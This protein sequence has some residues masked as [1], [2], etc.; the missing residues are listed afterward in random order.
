MYFKPN[1]ESA[2][3]VVEDGTAWISHWNMAAI[4]C[5]KMECLHRH[6][7][8]RAEKGYLCDDFIHDTTPFLGITARDCRF[9]CVA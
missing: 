9:P 2:A 3:V 4:R 1:W 5:C 7:L 6:R 8:A